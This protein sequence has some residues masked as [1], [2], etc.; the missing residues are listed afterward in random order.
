[1]RIKMKNCIKVILLVCLFNQINVFGQN[2][3]Q[4]CLGA[5]PICGT[6]VVPYHSG[7]EFND[8]VPPITTAGCLNDEVNSVWLF[9]QVDA[10]SP[11]G[12]TLT[13]IITPKNG[14]AADYDW[15]L[16]GPNKFCGNLGT[17]LRCSAAPANCFYCP[18]T[19]FIGG[20]GFPLNSEDKATGDG[21]LPLI[22]TFPGEGYYILV[23]NFNNDPGGFTIT[24]GGA[25]ILDCTPTPPCQMELFGPDDVTVCQ[26]EAGTFNFNV[27]E[28]G[29]GGLVDWEWT[30]KPAI[31]VNFMDNKYSAN[32]AISI[33]PSFSG[34]IV[35]TITGTIPICSQSDDVTVTVIP[36]PLVALEPIPSQICSTADPI[37]LNF[38][39]QGGYWEGFG[40]I[41]NG[42]LNPADWGPGTTTL[43]YKYPFANGCIAD[44]SIEVN[45]VQGPEAM[46]DY[47]PELCI[48]DPVTTLQG[49]ELGGK[50]GGVANAKGEI[51]P[52]KLGVGS[53]KVTYATTD[54]FCKNSDEVEITIKPLPVVTI[55]DPGPLCN[56]LPLFS[57]NAKPLKGTWLGLPDS[58]GKIM[59]NTL[60]AGNYQAI[61]KYKDLFGCK[62]SD[63]ID[64]K[65]NEK[66]TANVLTTAQVCNANDNNNISVLDFSAFVLSG[67]K[68][69]TWQD[70][71]G[72]GASGTL[73]VLDFLNVTPGK[74]IFRYTTN[75][76]IK[77]C[78]ES[79]YDIEIEVI[80]CKCPAIFLTPQTI[81]CN[82]DINLDLNKLKIN[83][84][85]G[86]WVVVASP[87]GSN[88]ANIAGTNLNVLDKDAGTYIL[89]YFL[90]V[91][92]PVGCPV[93][94]SAEVVINQAPKATVIST[95]TLCNK[96][97]PGNNPFSLDF[98]TLITGGD[99]SGTWKDITG[100]GAA[101]TLP[102]LNFINVTPGTYTFEYTTNSAIAPCTNKKYQVSIEVQDCECPSLALKSGLE[103]CNSSVNYDL[104][105]E[106]IT[107]EAGA[108]S[109]KSAPPGSNP[110]TLNGSTIVVQ[111]KDAGQYVLSFTLT[112]NPPVGCPKSADMTISIYG[113]P[114]ININNTST[115]CN[116]NKNGNVSVLD[117]NS[118]IT[119]GSKSGLWKD[120]N[121]S[122]AT[123]SNNLKDFNN[124]T[125][126]NYIFEFTG[127]TANFPCVDKTYSVT[128]TVKDCQCPGI[129]LVPL[130]QICNAGN[131]I[132][133]V[134]SLKITTEPGAWS[135][136]TKPAGANPA[137]LTG[138][139]FDASNALTGIY[140][141]SLTL[142]N[143]PPP[144]CPTSADLTIEVTAPPVANLNT[145]AK[146]CNSTGSGQYSTILDLYTQI[147]SGD[148][149]GTFKDVSNSGAKGNFS[150]LDFNGIT[151]GIYK[152][153]Y[154]T[155]SAVAP[156]SESV[157]F[158]DIVVENCECPSV[159]LSSK[160]DLCSDNASF[161]L[162]TLK[163]TTEAGTWS[164][165]T[166]A[167]GT[168]PATLNGTIFNGTNANAGKYT[169]Q[170]SLSSNP[171]PGCPTNSQVSFNIS[172]NLSSGISVGNIEL[173]QS[174]AQLINL[175]TQLTGASPGG[176]WKEISTKLSS[177][178]A[179]NIP[180]GLFNTQGQLP[181]TYIVEYIVT[182]GS[183]CSQSTT[184]I[185][186]IIDP[187]P[188]SDA[189]VDQSITCAVPDVTL[190][191]INS[192]VGP[193]IVYSWS[194]N[195]S[196]SNILNP[197]TA[198]AG[199][200]SLTVTNTIN[201]CSA[202]DA[203]KIDLANDLPLPENL[204]IDSIHCFGYTNGK[205]RFDKINGGTAPY[206]VYLN[207]VD[208]GNAQYFTKLKPGTYSLKIEDINGCASTH[209]IVL[210][211]PDKIYLELGE[212]ITVTLGD[213]VQIEPFINIPFNQI[214]TIIWSPYITGMCISCFE[215]FISPYY[216][217]PLKMQVVDKNGCSVDDALLITVDVERHIY[218]P[219][220]F[221]PNEDA[222]NDRF[223]PFAGDLVTSIVEFKIFDR[224]G[225]LVFSQSNFK[226]NNYDKGWDGSRNGQRL[227]AGVYVYYAVVE[228]KDGVKKIFKG[229]V[230][231][232]H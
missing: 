9:I 190:G 163:L 169:V 98:S 30:S 23:N 136:K 150:A 102:N 36:G 186:I 207:G 80:D 112:T 230:T 182:P 41:S 209:D 60:S 1:M 160:G 65:I 24:F 196:Q 132:V 166:Q 128:I 55:T 68:N 111:A 153:S 74:Y 109:I 105:L 50:W 231:L 33:P 32:P 203:V 20:Q 118:L 127:N 16:F 21:M 117:L 14:L 198:S 40:P 155:G 103:L 63:T 22:G 62:N 201:G 206:K 232:K 106:K 107:A 3:E 61:Y 83:A 122:G 162:E 193:N 2:S 90:N 91:T 104:D 82:D 31:A 18:N 12:G 56:D 192:S 170:F 123:G 213:S 119:S 35:Y 187:D 176:I 6:T 205:I 29:G 191:G 129:G 179:Q 130:T 131:A 224:W 43:T 34:Q 216:T 10:T 226:P 165:V 219:N 177:N 148:K 189:G 113:V 149:A 42:F 168:N 217:T 171:P 214:D 157:Y 69:G 8:F 212:D 222:L 184:T 47:V 151:P 200:Y 49:I 28:M 228:F 66:P 5:I 67:D 141:L 39:P 143:N 152:F 161:D 147:L 13:M 70:I 210:T 199:L 125:P 120:I 26:G 46:I 51:D 27:T 225:D 159:S 89:E 15:A 108:W 110:I 100:S 156:C 197:T 52:K 164:I 45:I 71:T 7:I 145:T 99:K 183:P 194:G 167:P 48:T 229:D 114:V 146:V 78:T 144:G 93:S 79:S 97:T 96:D 174:K 84:N 138:S 188:V 134:N 57:L 126:G 137:S 59:P 115:I 158:I 142:T 227:N 208:F 116:S 72:A 17:P 94:D 92:P 77:P 73:P 75:S 58:L 44:S 53:F 4:D 211:E 135:L 86:S 19:G 220:I 223:Y 95:K 154:T 215:P 172:Q 54:G 121:S 195:V 180:L 204:A 37:P 101:G 64:I 218:F 139:I 85:P 185:Q 175:A 76:A 88:N 178:N 140:V 181:G 173:C 25:T 202:V 81:L 221:S 38:S 87:P 133:D 11:P 124:I